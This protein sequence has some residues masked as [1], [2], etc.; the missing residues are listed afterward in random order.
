VPDHQTPDRHTSMNRNAKD[1]FRPNVAH[2]KMGGDNK[3]MTTQSPMGK[4]LVPLSD[5]KREFRLPNKRQ[6]FSGVARRVGMDQNQGVSS[7]F[8]RKLSK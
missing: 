7:E 4:Q 1:P 2:P 6:G 3:Q 5:G 8:S